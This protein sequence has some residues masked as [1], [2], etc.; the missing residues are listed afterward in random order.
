MVRLRRKRAS[1]SILSKLNPKRTKRTKKTKRTK[2]AT[3]PERWYRVKDI[4]DETET[5]YK[6]DW[7]DG[8]DGGKYDPSWVSSN[9]KTLDSYLETQT[10]DIERL[11]SWFYAEFPLGSQT[12]R[13]RGRCQGLG[14]QESKAGPELGFRYH[15][16]A[17][18]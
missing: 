17:Q 13:E 16:Q 8:E 3:T 18:F 2:R 11:H 14:D 1:N 12:P 9:A 10:V 15:S 6:I 5:E 4:I 7:E